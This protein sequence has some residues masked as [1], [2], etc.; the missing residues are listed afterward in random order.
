ME[1]VYCNCKQCDAT[2]GLFINL[3]TRVGKSYYSPIVDTSGD[4]AVRPDGDI[5]EGEAGTLV[6]EW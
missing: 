5:R 1:S 3:W 4:L 6:A 2:I